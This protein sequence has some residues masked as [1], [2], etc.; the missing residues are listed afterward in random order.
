MSTKPIFEK[1]LIK[2]GYKVLIVNSPTDYLEKLSKTEASIFT[3][4]SKQPFDFIQL[5]VSS[6]K[7]MENQLPK[8]KLLLKPKG[9]FWVTYP[10]GK[11][12]TNRDT[13]RTYAS[14]IGL[15]GVSMVA[16]DDIWSALRLKVV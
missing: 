9:I 1:L 3:N 15:Q 2:K 5:F 14:T 8:L 6:K 4:P 10:K 16:V 7:D 13:I 11:I 12:E